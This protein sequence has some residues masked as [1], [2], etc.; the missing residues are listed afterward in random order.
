AEAIHPGYGF[1]SENAS[2]ARAC[3]AAGVVFI[4]PGAQALEIMGDKIRAKEHVAAAGVPLVD[5]VS[6]PGLDDDALVEA[7][8]GMT[9]P[10]LIKP[11]A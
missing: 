2:F 6:A 4:G 8:A 7:A 3:E 10:V 11:S 1:L 5:G 9:Y